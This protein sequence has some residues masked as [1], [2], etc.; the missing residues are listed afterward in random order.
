M[1]KTKSSVM[2]RPELIKD[3][4]KTVGLTEEKTNKTTGYLTRRQLLELIVYINTLNNRL[5]SAERA[6]ENKNAV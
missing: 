2:R 6:V 1:I 3:L 4:C 5:R